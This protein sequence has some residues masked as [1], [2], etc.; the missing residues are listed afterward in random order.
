MEFDLGREPRNSNE[1]VAA[2]TVE[3]R[4]DVPGDARAEASHGTCTAACLVTDVAKLIAR[5]FGAYQTQTFTCLKHYKSAKAA[6]LAYYQRVPLHSLPSTKIASSTHKNG[7]LATVSAS[8]LASIRKTSKQKTSKR[9]TSKRIRLN[10]ALPGKRSTMPISK[11]IGVF[12]LAQAE[13]PAHSGV[14]DYPERFQNKSP[15]SAAALALAGTLAG[16]A[17]SGSLET[18]KAV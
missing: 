12:P 10:A 8:G 5:H 18:P 1:Q 6:D 11:T 4:C 7:V 17:C 14:V 13:M 9:E 16:A 3:W 15:L 2:S